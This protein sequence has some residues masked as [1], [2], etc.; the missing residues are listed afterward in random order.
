MRF[1]QVFIEGSDCIFAARR[2]Q[3]AAS[4]SSCWVGLAFA[5]ADIAAIATAQ[6]EMKVFIDASFK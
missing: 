2:I 3:D 1:R 5:K 6:S 4:L